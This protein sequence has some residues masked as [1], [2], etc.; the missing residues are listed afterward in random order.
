MSQRDM[1]KTIQDLRNISWSERASSSGTA[2][3]Y[4]K[5][6]TGSG[7]RMVYYK[8][9]RY[10]GI[11]IDGHE[12]ANEIVASRLMRVLGISH[13]EYRLIHAR[14]SINGTEHETWLNTSR[15][16]RKSGERKLGLGTFWELYRRED[17]TP[18]DFCLRH[19][20][21][22]EIHR[23]MLVDYLVANRDRHASNVEVLIARDG[24]VRLAPIFDTGFS[25]LAPYANDEER[26]LSFDPLADVATT[27]FIGSRS[28]EEN[29]LLTT[30]AE[31]QQRLEESDRGEI[32]RGLSDVLPQ[33]YL[34]KIWDIIWRRWQHYETLRAHR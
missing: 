34:G 20:W 5:A 29:V 30:E 10:N 13:L 4:L 18:Y 15:N 23:T 28:L 16:F 26:A 14:V 19:G 8:L 3:T 2:G 6:R 32:L 17:E 1:T 24:S 7:A 21:Q 12:C 27:N 25:L 33:T 22:N 31:L 11:V 9:S